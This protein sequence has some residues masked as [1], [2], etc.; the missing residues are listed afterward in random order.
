MAKGNIPFRMGNLLKEIGKITSAKNLLIQLHLL[1][2]SMEK[3]SMLMQ[4]ATN[5]SMF[6]RMV[7]FSK[8]LS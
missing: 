2:K 8:S 5:Q 4:K 7:Y 6:S 3:L 1:M